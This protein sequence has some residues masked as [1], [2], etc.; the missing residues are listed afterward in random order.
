MTNQEYRALEDAFLARHGT[1]RCAKIRTRWSAIVRPVPARVC[2]M[3]FA[4]RR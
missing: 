1:M 3:R 4:L 2:A